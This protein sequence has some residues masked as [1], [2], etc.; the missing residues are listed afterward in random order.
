ME[1]DGGNR[2]PL[3]CRGDWTNMDEL[4]GRNVVVAEGWSGSVVCESQPLT[5]G[6]CDDVP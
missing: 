1:A 4:G 6:A 5:L 3:A 2:R